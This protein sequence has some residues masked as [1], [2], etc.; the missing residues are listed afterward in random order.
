MNVELASLDVF[1]WCAL[2]KNLDRSNE[3]FG[4]FGFCETLESGRATPTSTSW[5][6]KDNKKVF[7]SMIDKGRPTEGEDTGHAE[8]IYF[9]EAI[10]KVS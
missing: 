4:V 9:K 7:E 6:E 10:R 3:V 5:A 1:L 8:Y 2:I